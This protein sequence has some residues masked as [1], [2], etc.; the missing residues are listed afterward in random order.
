MS[1][2]NVEK[3]VKQAEKLRKKRNAFMSLFTTPD[4]IASAELFEHVSDSVQELEEKEHYLN[5]SARTYLMLKSEYGFFRAAE[6]YEKL[7]N[8]FSEDLEK[9]LSYIE[10]QAKNLESAGKLM[11][12][13]Q[14]FQNAA[15]KA[16]AAGDERSIKYYTSAILVLEKDPQCPYHLKESRK[17]C[18]KETL[19]YERISDAIELFS[20]LQIKYSALCMQL[21]MAIEGRGLNDTEPEELALIYINKS[22]EEALAKLEEFEKDNFLPDYA[23]QVF[24]IAKAKCSPEND[25]C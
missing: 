22:R 5:E 18:L 19:R 6:M 14:S 13:G 7:G 24:K 16:E 10:L 1:S 12:A 23:A 17:K 20:K 25:I 11:Y 15:E 2:L 4:Y 21:L 8:I 9:A 3:N